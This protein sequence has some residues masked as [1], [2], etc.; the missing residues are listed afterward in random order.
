MKA[1]YP[2]LSAA[3]VIAIVAALAIATRQP[4]LFPSLGPTLFLQTVT[5]DQPAAKPWNTLA[6]HAIGVAAALLALLICGAMSDPA[7]LTSGVLT[8][9]RSAASALAIALT[10]AGQ[11]LL[12]AQHPPAAA[13]TLLLTLG[14]LQPDAVTAVALTAGIVLVGALG[15]VAR[16]FHPDR[17]ST[18]AGN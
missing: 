2:P 7:A 16:R 3:L 17:K 4:W 8:V 1:A 6:G 11:E 9:G 15:E 13:T 14:A 5:P 18:G 10:I 12:R